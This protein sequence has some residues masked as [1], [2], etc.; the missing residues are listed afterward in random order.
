MMQASPK[1]E[2]I[3][4]KSLCFA[5]FKGMVMDCLVSV[6]KHMSGGIN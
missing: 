3:L 2:A 5:N 4:L 1:Y 6:S